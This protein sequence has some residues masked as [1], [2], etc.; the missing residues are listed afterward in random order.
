MLNPLQTSWR[1]HSL[2]FCLCMWDGF[3]ARMS[4]QGI[5]SGLAY[6]MEYMFSQSGFSDR[7]FIAA[8]N[9][10]AGG[11]TLGLLRDPPVVIYHHQPAA[12][13]PTPLQTQTT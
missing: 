1:L 9:Q 11:L 2:I 6:I 13:P 5:A 7:P 8:V 12:A 10:T 3:C 4:K